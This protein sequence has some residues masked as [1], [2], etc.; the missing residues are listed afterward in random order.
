[1]TWRKER[2]DGDS[3][4]RGEGACA[5][6]AE[7][8]R[9]SDT[10][11]PMT[12][13]ATQFTAEELLRLPDDGHRHELV[14]GELRS[15]APA[16]G[17]HGVI[18]VRMTLSLGNHVRTHNLGEVFAAET[19][20]RI[21]TNPDTV[22]APDVAFV[23]RARIEQIELPKGYWP[24]AP[25][26]AIEVVSPSDS[27]EAVEEKVLDWLAA[28]T[29]MVVVLNPAKRTASVH[30]GAQ[31][32]LLTEHDTLSGGDVVPGWSVPVRDLFG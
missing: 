27:Y 29:Q 19:G 25:D 26:L 3:G 5:A 30:R 18:A 1:M 32:Q 9:A 12:S 16:G 22:R 15:M 7:V 20:F 14:K 4:I 10:I 6:T 2:R 24:G 23:S 17:M 31:A 11:S 13:V 8:M 21:A 28:G